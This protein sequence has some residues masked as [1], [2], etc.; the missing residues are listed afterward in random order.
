MAQ[1]NAVER[2]CLASLMAVVTTHGAKYLNT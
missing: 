1:I 2:A